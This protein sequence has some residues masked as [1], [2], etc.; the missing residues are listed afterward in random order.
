MNK[1]SI[2]VLPVFTLCLASF[3]YSKLP[4][5]ENQIPGGIAIIEIPSKIESATFNEKEVL[6]VNDDNKSKAL[7]GIS[8][9]T[10]PGT[11]SLLLS[12]GSRISFKVSSFA[13]PEQRIRLK[14]KRQ[15]NPNPLD[16][17]RIKKEASLQ[18][19]ATFLFNTNR[20]P[21]LE[22]SLPVKGIV[23]GPFGR[24]RFFN[25]Q[26]RRPHSGIDIAAPLGT[27][28]LASGDGE[29]TIV[30]D[31]FFNGKVVIIDHG[32]GI[33]TMYCHM[34]EIFVKAGDIVKKQ[35]V[36]GTVGSTGRSTGPH[37]HFGITL[38]GAW[39]DPSILVKDISLLTQ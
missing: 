34:S 9:A 14:N 18:R 37:L 17:A 11:H 12:N 16:L 23:S 24:K 8:L 7:V 26:P 21:S 30:G 2:F 33:N 13:Y 28:I 6:I 10:K 20:Y 22:M 38:N 15:V 1:F 35:E 25:D 4:I 3:A 36:I 39:I 29:I 27:E 19:N 31:F 32:H 5:K